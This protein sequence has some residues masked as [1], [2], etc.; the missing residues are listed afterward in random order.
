LGTGI[1]RDL[2]HRLDRPDLVV[3]ETD[4][5]QR[6]SE[7]DG[8]RVDTRLCV[9]RRD[10]HLPAQDLHPSRGAQHGLMLGRPRDKPAP[11]DS[12]KRQV[13]GLGAGRNERDLAASNSQ[14]SRH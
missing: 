1:H 6:G 14:Q 9:D 12:E 3:G 4:R 8:R 11:G 10:H 5:Y 2:C 13:D 7:F